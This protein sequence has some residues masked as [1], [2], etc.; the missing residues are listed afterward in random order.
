MFQVHPGHLVL[1][2]PQTEAQLV[3]IYL[4]VIIFWTEEVVD[5]LPQLLFLM[6]G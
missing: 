5:A 4:P 6:L 2:T 1:K 3:Q